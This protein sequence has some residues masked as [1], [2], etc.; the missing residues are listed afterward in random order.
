MRHTEFAPQRHQVLLEMGSDLPLH[1][2]SSYISLSQKAVCIPQA[3]TDPRSEEAV[4]NCVHFKRLPS[5]KAFFVVP[6]E[7]RNPEEL[8]EWGRVLFP[9]EEQIQFEALSDSTVLFMDDIAMSCLIAPT[10]LSED[11]WARI[12]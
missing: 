1:L 8:N 12:G 6:R 3:G 11:N 9:D 5:E 2:S 10:I 7:H 4:T